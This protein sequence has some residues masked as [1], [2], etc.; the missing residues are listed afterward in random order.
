MSYIIYIS[1]FVCF[2]DYKTFNI[3]VTHW[4]VPVGNY[5]Y[6]TCDFLTEFEEF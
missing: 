1:F 5:F 4:W 6:K 3:C 2:S